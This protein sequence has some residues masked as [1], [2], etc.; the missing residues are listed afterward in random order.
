MFASF[1]GVSIIFFI[2]IALVLASGIRVVPSAEEWV[3]ERLGKY[4]TTLKGGLNWII[5]F[6][7]QVRAKYNKQEQ[8][9][10]IPEQQVITKDNVGALVDGVV[11]MRIEDPERATYGA[12]NVKLMLAQIAQTTLRA[13]IGRLELDESLSSRDQI[14]KSLQTALGEAAIEWGV[15]VTRV[16]LSRIDVNEN[17]RLAMEKQM[18]AERDKRALELSAL[19]EKNAAITIA[20][21]YKQSERLKAEG[22]RDAIRAVNEAFQENP[23]AA[24][25]V[26]NKDRIAAFAKIAESDTVNK[27]VVPENFTAISGA[28][29]ALNEM[30]GK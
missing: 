28:L 3:I 18:A 4:R 17:V 26:L 12:L 29:T 6:V 16:E 30:N 20:E 25:Y 8:V 1:G 15:M 24:E 10:D 27:I 23:Q 13:E 11:F 14:N 9:V 5:P 21:G 22:E 7:D 2:L 19:G